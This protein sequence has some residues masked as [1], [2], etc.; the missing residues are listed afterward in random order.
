M[1]YLSFSGI[2]CSFFLLLSNIT[3][4]WQMTFYLT[5]GRKSWSFSVFVSVSKVFATLWPN[6]LQKKTQERRDFFLVHGFRGLFS[7]S[8][9]ERDRNRNWVQISKNLEVVLVTRDG[10]GSRKYRLEA[11]T[12]V[13]FQSPLHYQ[14]LPLKGS[15]GTFKAVPQAEHRACN[16]L[17]CEGFP[18]FN[19]NVHVSAAVKLGVFIF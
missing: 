2:Y 6:N 9:G 14:A 7:T 8:H 19:H 15:K 1:I 3:W 17:V 5:Y 16:T 11:G 10:P 4:C 13:T 18:D 12:R